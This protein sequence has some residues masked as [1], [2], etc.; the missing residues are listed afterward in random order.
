MFA[1]FVVGKASAQRNFEAKDVHL[2]LRTK[3]QHAEPK[4]ARVG[5]GVIERTYR[6][7]PTQHRLC[8]FLFFFFFVV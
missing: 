1:L 6:I 8:Q 7:P 5:K 2:W 3:V 4:A